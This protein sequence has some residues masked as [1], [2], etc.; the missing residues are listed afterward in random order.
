MVFALFELVITMLALFFSAFW[1]RALVPVFE[2]LFLATTML[3]LSFLVLMHSAYMPVFNLLD[4]AYSLVAKHFLHPWGY[5][6]RRRLIT[7]WPVVKLIGVVLCNILINWITGLTIFKVGIIFKDYCLV[8]IGVFVRELFAVLPTYPRVFDSTL[9]FPGEGWRKHHTRREKRRRRKKSW[10]KQ[11]EHLTMATWNTRSMT[12]ERF[13]YCKSLGYDILAV[14]EL[15]R[16]QNKFTSRSNEFTVSATVKDKHGN[17]KNPKDKAAGVGI[18]LSHRAQNKVLDKGNNDSERICWVRLEGPS[19]N[20]FVV[21]VYVPHSSRTEPSQSDTLKE[22]EA[23]C[24]HANKSDCVIVLG[25]FNAQLPGGLQG[26]TGAHVC[27]QGESTSATK[28]LNFMRHNDLCAINTKFRKRRTSP[29]TYLRVITSDQVDVNDQHVGR[30]VKASWQGQDH[31]GEI[32]E[33]L[34]NE[35]GGRLW[36]AKFNDGYIKTYSEEELENAMVVQKRETEGRQLD[37]VLVSNRWSSSVQDA[38]VRWGPSEH[39]NIKGKADHALVY[40]NWTWKLSCPK[41]V[42]KKDLNALDA[43]TEKGRALIKEFDDAVT[44][45]TAELRAKGQERTVEQQ[46]ADLRTAITHAIEAVLPN[47]QTSKRTKREVSDRTKKL[48]E[49]RTKMGKAKTKWSNADYKKIQA[50]IKTSSLKDHADWVERCASEMQAAND[51]GD[52]RKLHKVVKTLSGKDDK[53]PETDISIN[54]STKKLIAGPEERATVW[55]AFLRKKFAPTQTEVEDRPAMPPLPPRD[56]GNTLTKDEVRRAVK[57]LKKHKAVGADGIPVEVYQASESAFELLAE[58]L[59]RVWK[60]EKV[61]EELGEAIFKMIYKNKGS[62]EDPRK[63][64]CIGLLNSAYKVLSAVML[65][66]LQRET[67]SYLKDWQAGFRQNRGCRDN[68][69]I[70]R[71]LVDRMLREDKPLVL[72]FIDYAAAF[73]TLGH[74]FLDA[75]LGDAK[76]EPKTRAIFRAIYGSATARTKVQ[77]TNGKVVFSERFSIQRGVLQGDLTSPWYFILALEAIFRA[78]DRGTAKGVRLGDTS[79]HTLGYADDCALIDSSIAEASARVTAIAQGSERDADMKI[80]IDKTEC[81]HV[82]RQQKV[83]A[84]DHSQAEKVC[85]HQCDNIGCGWFFG[86]KLGLIIH[87]AKWCIWQNYYE[88]EKILDMRCDKLPAGIGKCSFLI[89]WKGYSQKHNSWR[90]YKDVTKAAITEYLKASGQYDHAWEHRCHYCDKP[91]QTERGKKIHYTR[92]CKKWEKEQ[93]YEGTVASVLHAEEEK[94]ERQKQMER[95]LCQHSKLKNCYQFKYLGSMFTADGTEDF[96]LR[97]RIGIAM[98]RSGQ[99]R[100]IMQAKNVSL[101]TKMKIYRCAVGSLFT[102]GSEA[103]TLSEKTIRKLNG[104]NAS[105]LC[106]FTGKSRVEESRL[107]TCTYSLTQ[108]IRQRR[109]IWLGHILRMDKQ[110]LV[111]KAAEQQF[112]NGHHGNLFMDVP[113]SKTFEQLVEM[114][115]DRKAWKKLVKAQFGPAGNAPL[116]T[117]KTRITI[118]APTT[119]TQKSETAKYRARDECAMFFSKCRTRAQKQLYRQKRKMKRPRPLTDAERRAFALAHWKKHHGDDAPIVTVNAMKAVFSSSSDDS[120]DSDLF[121]S[122][123]E[124]DFV[125]KHHDTDNLIKNRT[126]RARLILLPDAPAFIP[127]RSEEEVALTPAAVP[128]DDECSVPVPATTTM[129]APCSNLSKP[130]NPVTP[131]QISNNHH[132]PV[133]SP[134]AKEFVPT[135]PP[136]TPEN[137]CNSSDT[138]AHWMAAAHIPDSPTTTKHPPHSTSIKDTHIPHTPPMIHGHY[139]P[140]NFNY[141]QSPIPHSNTDTP[142]LNIMN[143][144]INTLDT[145]K[146]P[147]E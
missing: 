25:D 46:Y 104:A 109:L 33:C 73:D 118:N 64:R 60:E 50:E 98:T 77:G 3:A 10:S 87:K 88:V 12:R 17:L 120:C 140:L 97:R 7:I 34:G 128:R 127:T 80:N 26:L 40:C 141:T 78:H 30:E 68:V 116:P 121:N 96:D 20:L 110:R 129:Q 22:L 125:P 74:K 42:V 146:I 15:W 70:L 2:I 82:K 147:P 119:I 48:F 115:S 136:P 36:K 13:E 35:Q 113:K 44:T 86:S 84:P 106:R 32:V 53:K 49:R 21:A 94:A 92:A 143:D 45:K 9:G 55:G 18:I 130:M 93:K 132:G 126:E 62:S 81:M 137:S 8:Q 90:P 131:P 123:D 112:L 67:Q 124:T 6:I 144:T 72:T 27:A 29:A 54:P 57:S 105:C 102:Y 23:V 145:H 117:T 135:A 76:A 108:D 95:I 43:K 52:T 14:T 19:C 56:Q 16:S 61:P 111:W 5:A 91:F 89:K 28:V 79:V 134:Q 11:H 37:Y 63:Y 41:K 31:F 133:L 114:A 122:S 69:M 59:A 47:T 101:S 51:V 139:Q 107:A 100:F 103:W 85:K 65:A 71:T 66:R 75:T 24:K 1:R 58:L 38:G 138:S 39:R 4:N 142:Q 83:T 99:L